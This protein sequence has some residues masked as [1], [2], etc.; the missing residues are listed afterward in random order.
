MGSFLKNQL[1]LVL[2]FFLFSIGLVHSTEKFVAEI[3][4]PHTSFF[5]VEKYFSSIRKGKNILGR[6]SF[7]NNSQDGFKLTLTSTNGGKLTSTDIDED[8][9][10]IPYI[11]TLNP[12]DRSLDIN[13]VETLTPELHPNIEVP[14]LFLSGVAQKMSY[15]YYEVAIYIE[16][17][18]NAL[19]MAGNYKDSIMIKYSD[20]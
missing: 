4:V 3:E 15:G 1:I 8:I 11:L 2:F 9:F 18:T 6:F 12:I 17:I 5:A 7:R 20:L 13:V 14:F 10:S 19:Q 16:D